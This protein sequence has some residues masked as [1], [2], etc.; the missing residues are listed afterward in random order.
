MVDMTAGLLA[1]LLFG[2]VIG[3]CI[4]A[5]AFKAVVYAPVRIEQPKGD[6]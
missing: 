1:G 2:T 4:S 6:K 5:V 3:I